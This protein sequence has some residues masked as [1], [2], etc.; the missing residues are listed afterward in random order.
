MLKWLRDNRNQLLI[1]II[2]PLIVLILV[3]LFAKYVLERN[4]LHFLFVETVTIPSA[5]ITASGIII[6]IL[7]LLVVNLMENNKTLINSLDDKDVKDEPFLFRRVEESD[8]IFEGYINPIF[9]L[10]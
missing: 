10:K 1:N 9:I 4:I 6:L 5:I 2:S 3:A 8:L 7:F